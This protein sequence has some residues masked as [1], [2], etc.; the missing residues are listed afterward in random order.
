MLSFFTDMAHNETLTLSLHDALP[1][2]I[3]TGQFGMLQRADGG[4]QA[5][6]YFVRRSAGS[7]GGGSADSNGDFAG[8]SEAAALPLHLPHAVQMHRNYGN[9]QVLREQSDARLKRRHAPVLGVVHFAFRKNEDA[10]TAIDRFT[11]KAKALAE[12]GELRQW[13]N[14]EEG[15]DQPVAKLVGP[16]F[17]K[18]PI[19]RRMTHVLQSFAAHRGCKIVAVTQ[20]ECG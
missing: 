11:G 2:S 17:C 13:E 15:D 1:I 4:F 8:V 7:E 5:A 14:V 12:A 9:A 3:A 6:S 20:W 16:P 10:V 19:A 18:K